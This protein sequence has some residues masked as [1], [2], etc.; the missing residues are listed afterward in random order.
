MIKAFI[1]DMDGTLMDSD[2]LWV[3][4][5]FKYLKLKNCPLAYDEVM[6]IVYGKSLQSIY[7]NITTHFPQLDIGITNLDTEIYKIFITLRDT[8]NICIT[9]SVNLLKQLAET[10]PVSIVSGATRRDIEECLKIINAEECISFY[11]GAEDY[12]NGKPAPDCFL[13]AADKFGVLPEECLVF[14]DS[15]AGVTAAKDAGMYCVA[16][17]RNSNPRQDVERADLILDDLSKFN[18]TEFEKEHKN[19]NR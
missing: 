12:S 16:L 10:Y 2:I 1:F 8:D 11:L 14:E 4:A 6:D 18:L 7:K 19:A 13:M 9:T 15:T 17:A 3:D 5:V